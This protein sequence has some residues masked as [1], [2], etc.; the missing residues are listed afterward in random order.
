MLYFDILADKPAEATALIFRD[1]K[2]TYGE[3]RAQINR[4]ANFLQAKGLKQGE[5][6]GLFSKNC[7]DYVGAYFAVIKA[8]GVVIPLNYQLVPREVAYIVK[9]SHMKFLITQEKLSL[10]E[11]LTE[12]NYPN[13]EQLTYEDMRQPV[14]HEFINYPQKEG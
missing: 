14:N 9:D 5:K 11:V 2:T 6:V 4:W 12:L 7:S 10:A 8:G 13:I 3:L 1:V